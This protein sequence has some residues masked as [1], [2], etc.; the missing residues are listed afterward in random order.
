MCSSG[1][2]SDRE[3]YDFDQLFAIAKV[4]VCIFP[5][6]LMVHMVLTCYSHLRSSSRVFFTQLGSNSDRYTRIWPLCGTR[7]SVDSRFLEIAITRHNSSI[8]EIPKNIYA[9]RTFHLPRRWSTC[10]Y[11]IY[12]CVHCF[13]CIINACMVVWIP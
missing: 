7:G 9:H 1:D 6:S 11:S 5:R 4:Q 8:T 13:R 10:R 2:L 12:R 3:G